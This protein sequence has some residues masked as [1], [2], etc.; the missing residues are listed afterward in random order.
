MKSCMRVFAIVSI[1]LGYTS[2]ASAT[3]ITFDSHPNDPTGLVYTTDSND[4]WNTG[5]GLQFGLSEDV[6]IDS[7]GVLQDFSL[8]AGVSMDYEVYDV[9]NNSVLR[10][11]STGLVGTTGLEFI[12]VSFAALQLFAGNIYH[13]EFSFS[14]VSNQNFYHDE[15]G[16]LTHNQG[17]FI[18]IDSTSGGPNATS[19][20][21]LAQFR[22]NIVSQQTAI[23]EPGIL[24]LFVA[25]LFGVRLAR[26]G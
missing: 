19:N 3:L 1:I 5:R 22:T 13:M 6:M 4:G 10:S 26:K 16:A 11:G 8:Q 20:Y 9:T 14:A 18:N 2:V 21:V 24:A 7:F 25:A 12:D 15:R 17:P 23:P